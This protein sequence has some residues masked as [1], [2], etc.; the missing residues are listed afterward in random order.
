VYDYNAT[1]V[2]VIDG[3]TVVLDFDLGLSTHRHASV[4]LAGIDA[5]ERS[6]DKDGLAKQAVL[7]WFW[8]T[9]GEVLVKTVKDKKTFDRY[10]GYVNAK[11]ISKANVDM[12]PSLSRYMVDRGFAIEVDYGIA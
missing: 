12:H 7:D 3:D 4:R 2:R 5:I 6:E 8:A 9:S 10:V 11:H 1:L